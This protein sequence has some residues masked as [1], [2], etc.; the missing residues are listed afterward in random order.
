[1]KTLGYNNNGAVIVELNE[2][3]FYAF[4]SLVLGW[5]GYP[6]GSQFLPDDE[7]S[8]HNMAQSLFNAEKL[9]RNLPLAKE[10]LEHALE[11][12][13]ETLENDNNRPS[14]NQI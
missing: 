14:P 9:F 12:I 4:K 7:I 8:M 6:H 2:Q 10:S 11:K 5:S 13:N 3:E 1:M